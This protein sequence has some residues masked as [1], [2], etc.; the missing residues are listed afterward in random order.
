VNVKNKTI[1]YGYKVASESLGNALSLYEEFGYHKSEKEVMKN[2]EMDRQNG[3]IGEKEKVT[4]F[5][6]AIEFIRDEK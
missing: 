1:G 6:V 3:N 2:I 4:I 5:K